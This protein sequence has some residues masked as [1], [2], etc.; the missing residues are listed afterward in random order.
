MELY[1]MMWHSAWKRGSNETW[2]QI[3]SSFTEVPP[4]LLEKWWSCIC[5]QFECSRGTTACH[6]IVTW[7][8]F[9]SKSSLL[10]RSW[11][12]SNPAETRV[13][14]LFRLFILC[15]NREIMDFRIMLKKTFG[16][17]KLQKIDN[18]SAGVFVSSITIYMKT[19]LE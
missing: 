10:C 1:T 2:S 13:K 7:P 5:L 12:V 17:V 15:A 19:R 8:F 16:C 3:L 14:V 18:I 4:T 6:V 11:H 9:S